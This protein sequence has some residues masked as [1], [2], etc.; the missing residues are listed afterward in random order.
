MANNS[1]LTLE[2]VDLVVSGEKQG[3]SFPAGRYLG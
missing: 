3:L 1:R 2:D